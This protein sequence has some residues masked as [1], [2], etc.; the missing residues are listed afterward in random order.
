MKCHRI[1]GTVSLEPPLSFLVKYFC[2]RNGKN[3]EILTAL[4]RLKV[5]I[6]RD[7]QG[8]NSL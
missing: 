1:H 3:I 5:N 8:L 2:L 4:K 7:R 6:W